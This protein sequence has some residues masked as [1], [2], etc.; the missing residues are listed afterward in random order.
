MHLQPV[1]RGSRKVKVFGGNVAENLFRRGI[2][3]PSGAALP[4]PLVKIILRSLEVGHPR[5]TM[6]E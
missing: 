1:F 5:P 3:L 2:C 4:L 6:D